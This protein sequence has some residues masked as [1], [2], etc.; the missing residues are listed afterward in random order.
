M[1]PD[2]YKIRVVKDGQI[3]EAP[4]EWLRQ[5]LGICG[6]ERRIHELEKPIRMQK[7]FDLLKAQGKP[8]SSTWL[9]NWIS[10]FKYADLIALEKEGKVSV[11]RSGSHQ[12]WK[13][14]S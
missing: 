6:M 8:R 9:S 1:S 13:V 3:L 4:K 14:V 11:F 12:M 2:E 5:Y 7:I 10:D